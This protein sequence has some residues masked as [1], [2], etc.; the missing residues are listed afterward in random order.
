MFDPDDKNVN[1]EW[2]IKVKRG[3]AEQTFHSF[4][5]FAN[6]LF[7]PYFVRNKDRATVLDAGPHTY[8]NGIFG[9]AR[10][11]YSHA[12]VSLKDLRDFIMGERRLPE[13]I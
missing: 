7:F 10:A 6:F 5:A 8:S 11:L 4:A 13:P 2:T 9:A 3:E 1:L 12:G